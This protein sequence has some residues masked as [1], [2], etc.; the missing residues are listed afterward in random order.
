[1]H[2]HYLDIGDNDKLS[3]LERIQMALNKEQQTTISND[4]SDS[5]QKGENTHNSTT[6]GTPLVGENSEPEEKSEPEASI[7][8]RADV[9][10]K[11]IL[12]SFRKHYCKSF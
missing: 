12:R 11:Y 6:E 5:H 7:M 2:Q 3:M 10:F 9:L 8:D 4:G 1:M